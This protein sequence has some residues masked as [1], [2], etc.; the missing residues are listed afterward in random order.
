MSDSS[1]FDL[2]TDGSIVHGSIGWGWVALNAGVEWK[3][4][5]GGVYGDDNHA[6][7][8]LAALHGL[9]SLP[10]KSTVTLFTDSQFVIKQAER[11]AFRK[12]R[13][14]ERGDPLVEKFEAAIGLHSLVT[15]EYVPSHTS[16]PWNDVADQLA[17]HAARA[18]KHPNP[19]KP[20]KKGR[21]FD[22]RLILAK[23]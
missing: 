13:A 17:N 4:N 20:R 14:I 18:A 16:I 3:R 7:E 21:Q 12:L 9:R 10:P 23:R 15:F 11:I 5:S 1:K 6:A 19:G 8:T 22:H 2:Y